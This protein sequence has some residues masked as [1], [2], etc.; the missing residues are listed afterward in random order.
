MT[1]SNARAKKSKWSN[2]RMVYGIET[3][4]KARRIRMVI[5]RGLY[6]CMHK[7]LSNFGIR[8]QTVHSIRV[9]AC[10]SISHTILLALYECESTMLNNI[11]HGK[12]HNL[13]LRFVIIIVVVYSMRSY[14]IADCL[15]V[16]LRIAKKSYYQ[17]HNTPQQTKQ[18]KTKIMNIC[19]AVPVRS[20]TT[21]SVESHINHVVKISEQ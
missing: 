3:S 5:G 4:S 13:L 16:F 7:R 1:T 11:F 20:T 12:N 2:I 14:F 10:V 17:K 18:N 8:M 6:L 21:A 9:C 15:R 19:R